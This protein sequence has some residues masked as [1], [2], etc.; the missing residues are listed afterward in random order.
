MI[1]AT[2]P[3]STM[4]PQRM[5]IARPVYLAT[6]GRSWLI[7]ISAVSRPPTSAIIRSSTCFWI[8]A[9]SAVVGSSAISRSGSSISTEASMMRWRMPPENTCG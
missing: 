5:T 8:T 1:S 2:A 3:V 7:R 4:H 6:S 9:S